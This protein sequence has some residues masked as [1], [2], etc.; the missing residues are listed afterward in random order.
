MV[1]L[2]SVCVMIE[3]RRDD[4]K[5]PTWREQRLFWPLRASFALQPMAAIV[6]FV[7]KINNAG[8]IVNAARIAY[9]YV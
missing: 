8:G 9:L 5:D 3:R 7:Q 2:T 6:R 1:L 4:T